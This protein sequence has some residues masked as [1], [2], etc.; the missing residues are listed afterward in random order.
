MT[1][2][3]N[4]EARDRI[5]SASAPTTSTPRDDR[6]IGDIAN[7]RLIQ[8]YRNV[9]SALFDRS[10]TF[11]SVGPGP[12]QY[13]GHSDI[14]FA[15][16]DGTMI[17]QSRGTE[18]FFD[19]ATTDAGTRARNAVESLALPSIKDF[20]EVMKADGIDWYA[21]HLTYGTRDFRKEK[22]ADEVSESVLVAWT[23][24]LGQAYLDGRF[25]GVEF[26]ELSLIVHSNRN[27]L[28]LTR[29]KIGKDAPSPRR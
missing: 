12:V 25:S 3:T 26:M 7:H 4:T 24:E 23:K 18:V 15:S 8:K 10:K 11:G 17:I 2:L 21:I 19:S 6:F 16:F 5:L 14:R 29:L 20:Q 27:V 9:I 28:S 13:F 1:L 22:A